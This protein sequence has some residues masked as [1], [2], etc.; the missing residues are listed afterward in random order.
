MMAKVDNTPELASGSHD[1]GLIDDRRQAQRHITILQVARLISHRGEDLCMIRNISEGG[2][3]A[4]SYTDIA[5]GES[6]SFEFKAG[7]R[8][9]GQVV[10]KDGRHFGVSFDHPES[11]APILTR[12]H[13]VRRGKT[14]R[15]PRFESDAPV[16][17]NILGERV[18]GTL[19]DISQGGMK[20]KCPRS[21]D[22]GT[23]LLAH[24]RGLEPRRAV[25]RWQDGDMVGLIFV[26][27]IP[28]AEFAPWRAAR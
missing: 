6:L 1:M 14:I 27:P 23:N 9:T 8:F 26:T 3:Q 24:V 16:T 7:E 13:V 28:F 25:V 18:S 19:C 4:E 2:L 21:L 5:I 11:I 17:L 20:M 12:K 22:N 10:W 15:A